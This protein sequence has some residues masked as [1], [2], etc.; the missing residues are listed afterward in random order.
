ME[1]DSVKKDNKNDICTEQLLKV[2]K[3]LFED[4]LNFDIGI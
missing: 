3:L 2:N 1:I 4:I